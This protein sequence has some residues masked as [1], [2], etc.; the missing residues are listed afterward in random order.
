[1]D[2][3]VTVP[4]ISKSQRENHSEIE[5]KRRER[6]KRDTEFLRRQIPSSRYKDK[7]SIFQIGAER[8]IQYTDKLGKRDYIIN[9]EEYSRLIMDNFDGFDVHIR[10]CDGE[11]TYIHKNVEGILDTSVNEIV[12][13]RI[14]DLAEPS[15]S[16]KEI[17]NSAFHGSELQWD[18]FKGVIARNFILAL[19]CGPHVPL[20]HC[21]YGSD[22]GVYRF[23]E[24]CGDLSHQNDSTDG[25]K[26]TI[27]FRGLCRSLDPACGTIVRAPEDG[28]HSPVSLCPESEKHFTL[29]LSKCDHRIIETVGDVGSLLGCVPT[30]LLHSKIRDLVTPCEQSLVDRMLNEAT[31]SGVAILRRLHLVHAQS[32][33]AI[34][35]DARLTAVRVGGQVYCF[36]C[37]LDARNRPISSDSQSGRSTNECSLY[38]ANFLDNTQQPRVVER[39]PSN[40]G[41]SGYQQIHS[42]ESNFV[43]PEETFGDEVNEHARS[44]YFAETAP[45]S[46][47]ERLLFKPSALDLGAPMVGLRDGR[48]G[49]QNLFNDD[50][51]FRQGCFM[52][53]LQEDIDNM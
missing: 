3:Q 11:I 19:R 8:L 18:I 36:V 2:R 37:R 53:M 43:K 27:V 31:H 7:L 5:R 45:H 33:R 25:T 28:D 9:D 26:S 48:S 17:I 6:M 14:H 40:S 34:E 4:R 42:Y 51:T 1:M 50:K 13:N 39:L 24:F 41:S 32:R 21:V 49:Y 12:G 22:G 47:T 15:A 46:V 10:C 35:F 23:I 38:S 29:R 20:H 30:S 44:T 52:D 16:T